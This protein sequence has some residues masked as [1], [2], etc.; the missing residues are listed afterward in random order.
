[1]YKLGQIK[2]L[3]KG[4]VLERGVYGR[5]QKNLLRKVAGDRSRVEGSLNRKHLHL[6]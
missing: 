1:M 4:N 2:I 5:E 6:W 3:K